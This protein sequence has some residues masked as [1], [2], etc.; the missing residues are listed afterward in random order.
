MMKFSH[1]SVL[2]A[3]LSVAAA[4]PAAARS[5]WSTQSGPGTAALL[6]GQPGTANSFRLDCSAKGMSLSTWT[7]RLPRNITEG[8]FPSRLSVFQGNREI[9]LGGT[10]R[11][12]PEGGTRVDALVESPQAFLDGMGRN[13][14]FVVVNFSGRGT[15]P[16]PS[17]EQLKAHGDACRALRP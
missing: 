4:V 14:R 3:I 11:V 13:S 9:V 15:A 17:A 2:I 7:T 5:S 8:E 6:F 1:A 16:A 12:L 10:G